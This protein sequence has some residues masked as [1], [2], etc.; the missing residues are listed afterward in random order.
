MSENPVNEEQNVEYLREFND[1]IQRALVAYVNS[2]GGKIY[3]GLDELGAASGVADPNDAIARVLEVARGAVVPSVEP[4][5]DCSVETVSGKKIVVVRV[6]RGSSRPFWLASRGLT[7]DG[8]LVRESGR[9]VPCSPAQLKKALAESSD[10]SYE[11]ARSYAQNLTFEYAT[12]VFERAKLPF[13][14][15][16]FAELG[17][18]DDEGV[19]TNRALLLSDQCP[20]TMKI[21]F[22]E[23]AYENQIHE[24]LEITGSIFRQFDDVY[25]YLDRYNREY[26]QLR[27]AN[28]GDF[29]DFPPEIIREILLNAIVHRDYSADVKTIVRRY[30]DRLEVVSYGGLPYDLTFDEIMLGVS[31]TRNP[32]LAE[33]FYQLQL[34]ETCGVGVTKIRQAYANYA[35]KPRFEVSANFF[36]ATIYHA[37]G[38]KLEKRLATKDAVRVARYTPMKISVGSAPAEPERVEAI[39][40]EPIKRK[41]ATISG[42]DALSVAARDLV[43]EPIATVKRYALSDRERLVLQMFNTRDVVTCRDV[44]TTLNLTQ[45]SA[46]AIL[47]K[48]VSSGRIVLCGAGSNIWYRRP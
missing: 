5:V 33:V 31:A 24:R 20:S 40:R 17:L 38:Q 4:Y 7:V 8:A 21:A 1:Q 37:F 19:F 41:R 6:S 13:G 32:K 34:I 45:A 25:A 14:R 3:I 26:A 46:S 42:R 44:E 30:H 18:R 11:R 2:D 12:K 48:L 43:A 15:E 36:K 28:R 10:H 9:N 35:R 23:G 47:R 27:G 29:R 22:F 16:Q 39:E